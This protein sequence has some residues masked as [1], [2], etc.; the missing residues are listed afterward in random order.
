MFSVRKRVGIFGFLLYKKFSCQR[1]FFVVPKGKIHKI[2]LTSFSIRVITYET[3]Y[4]KE[5]RA[6]G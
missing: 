6:T 1:I 4:I 2:Y 5:V 3:V